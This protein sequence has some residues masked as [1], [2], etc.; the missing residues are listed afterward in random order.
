MKA[1]KGTGGPVVA[2]GSCLVHQMGMIVYLLHALV[3]TEDDLR[4]GI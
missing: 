2:C 1:G 3:P 4:A